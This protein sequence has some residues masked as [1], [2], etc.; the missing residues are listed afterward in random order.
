M[1]R[2]FIPE[3]LGGVKAT[4]DPS[5][6]HQITRVLRLHIQ[7]NIIFF[8][9][10]G[11]ECLYKIREIQKKK[12][13]FEQI[14]RETPHGRE[15]K[16]N[17]FLYQALPNK[18]EKVEYIIQ[19]SIEIGVK[20]IV[21]FRAAR[22][23]KNFVTPSKRQRYNKIATEALEQSWGLFP[24]EI[25]FLDSFP[26]SLDFLD[27][28]QKIFMDTQPSE[29]MVHCISEID[30]SQEDYSIFIWPEWWWDDEERLFFN[31]N[32]FINAHFWERIMRTETAGIVMAFWI[33]H[34]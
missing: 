19:K 4:T 6:I 24:I 14:S 3:E 26:S 11:G 7:D 13:I 20:K 30:T 9:W 27:G 10:D 5:F 17:I 23:Q 29:Q 12:I 22:S 18:S 33:I 28:Y 16:K 32:R 8:N 25:E 2:F 31:N 1:Q 34:Y 21:F 15:P